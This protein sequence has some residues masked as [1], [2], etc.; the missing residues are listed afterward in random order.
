[1]RV[2]FI[3][4]LKN[5]GKKGEIKEVADGYGKNFLIKNGYAVMETVTSKDI[6]N[7][8]NQKETEKRNQDIENANKI[9]LE[10]EKIELVFEVK[11]GTSGKV[12]GTVSTKTIATEL[13]KRGYD[14]DKKKI[15]VG[16]HLQTLGTHVIEIELYKNINANLKITLIS[17]WLYGRENNAP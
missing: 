2:I 6:L 9:K 5:Q 7:K 12:F 1:M 16:E 17:R 15:I 8:Q 10:L 3:K 11:S 13:L 14:F 4:D